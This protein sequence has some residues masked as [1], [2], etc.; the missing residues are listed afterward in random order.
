[1]SHLLSDLNAR[2]AFVLRCSLQPPWSMRIEDEAP[3]SVVAVVRG[4]A[5]ICPDGADAVLVRAGDVAVVRGPRHYRVSDEIDSQPQVLIRPGQVC[6]PL[7]G[8]DTP[9]MS[10][11]GVRTWG[12]A[13]DGS[14]LMLDGTYEAQ[15]TIGRRLLSNLPELI[16]VPREQVPAALVSYLAEQISRNDPGQDVVL[17]RLLDLMLVAV[18]R[19]WF[20]ERQVE[21]PNWYRAHADP[22]I[23]RALRLMQ[24]SPASAW[25]VAGLATETGLSRAA[26][27]R[28]FS[29]LVGEPPMAFLT[30]W[31]LALAAD[32]LSESDAT[33]TSVAAKVGYATPFAFSAAFKRVHG[34]SPQQFRQERGAPTLTE[35]SMG[36]RGIQR[37]VKAE[38]NPPALHGKTGR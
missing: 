36:P 26:F 38:A 18:L 1:M 19:W 33:I 35:A 4:Q 2:D 30:N 24:G 6:I 9:P 29:D 3:V 28:R 11:V 37:R 27:A 5:Y 7:A 31:R 22:V 21:E 23:G 20:A 25:T 8:A 15:N 14:T 32:L 12:N 16:V 13:V 10:T 17:D 34:V